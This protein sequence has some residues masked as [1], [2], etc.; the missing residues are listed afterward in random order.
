MKFIEKV[1][2]DMF[3]PR[4]YWDLQNEFVAMVMEKNNI[5]TISVRKK[6]TPITEQILIKLQA[7]PN[8]TYITR[9]DGIDSVF[10]KCPSDKLNSVLTKIEEICKTL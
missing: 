10:I 3:G 5:S 2:D 7:E 4:D 9:G 6:R 8:Y 1:P